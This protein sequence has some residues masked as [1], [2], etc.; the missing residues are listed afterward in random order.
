MCSSTVVIKGKSIFFCVWIHRHL[1]LHWGVDPIRISVH[2]LPWC[3]SSVQCFHQSLWFRHLSPVPASFDL[4]LILNAPAVQ[5]EISARPFT[6][7]DHS[8]SLMHPRHLTLSLPSFIHN[9][10]CCCLFRW[11]RFPTRQSAQGTIRC[12]FLQT[13]VFFLRFVM[14]YWNMYPYL[15]DN[16]QFSC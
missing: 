2:F 15:I 1:A 9:L 5:M 6:C 13:D 12:Y 14:F 8:L 10:N 11:P 3:W 4:H 7:L 16:K